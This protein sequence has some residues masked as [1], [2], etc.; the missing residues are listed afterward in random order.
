[1]ARKKPKTILKTKKNAVNLDV[2]RQNLANTF[3]KQWVEKAIAL[4]K[5]GYSSS[6]IKQ[7]ILENKQGSKT[8][9]AVDT[10]MAEANSLIV[11]S[12][13]TKSKELIPVHIDRYNKIIKKLFEV[14]DGDDL[15]AKGEEVDSER[16]WKLRE[17]KIRAYN[18]CI[19]TH[20]QK[21]ELLQYHKEGFIIN[22]NTEEEVIIK[23]TKPKINVSKLSYEDLIKL[24]Q[25]FKKAR[26]SDNDLLAIIQANQE[27]EVV[28][29]DVSHEVVEK[30]NIEHIKQ[31]KLPDPPYRS[32]ITA[33]DPTIKLRE[34]LQKLAAKRFGE[35][36]TLTE[37]EKQLTK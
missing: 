3:K 18:D 21:E 29:E 20:R 26:K 35:V 37:E 13:I 30:P 9:A 23:E 1:M 16:Y 7:Y 34:S 14:E 4:M 36:G 11:N 2:N 27:A 22:L 28:T 12:Q 24:Y 33:N 6:Y 15:I 31:E 19:N 10:I 25:F 17:R 32:P 5:E 8:V